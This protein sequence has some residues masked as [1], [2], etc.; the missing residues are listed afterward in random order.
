MKLTSLL[1]I[2][3]LCL[4][5]TLAYGQASRFS[6][7]VQ[8]QAR[9]SDLIFQHP[10]LPGYEK[11]VRESTTWRMSPGIAPWVQY[12]LNQ[13][14]A[15]LARIGY[16]LSG[17]VLKEFVLLSSTPQMPEPVRIGKASGVMHYHDLSYSF[18][19]KIKPFKQAKQFYLTGGF[20]Q[21]LSLGRYRTILAHLDSG[22]MIKSTEQLLNQV[23]MDT[24]RREVHLG[25]FRA[26]IGFGFELKWTEKIHCYV[27]PMFG[28]ALSP[29]YTENDG[30]YRQYVAGLN[31]GIGW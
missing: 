20:A 12:R 14:L 8:I 1:P 3:G 22:N 18:G 19:V 5:F 29:V 13:R 24:N 17:Y 21:L 7:G 2:V 23:S 16:E 25:Y 27:E 6:Y 30:K 28:Y 11:L 9:F 15:F 4:H 31:M 10:N 26:D